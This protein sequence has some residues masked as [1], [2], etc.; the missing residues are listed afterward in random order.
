MWMLLVVEF[1]V[2]TARME[3]GFGELWEG[4]QD[5]IVVSLLNAQNGE[6]GL[7]ITSAEED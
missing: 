1:V 6:L 5:Y 4:W 3:R 2:V 7:V